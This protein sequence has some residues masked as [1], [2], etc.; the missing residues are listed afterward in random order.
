MADTFRIVRPSW[1]GRPA[2]VLDLNAAPYSLVRDSLALEAGPLNPIDAP[3]AGRWGGSVVAGTTPAN[4]TVAVELL[5]VSSTA[6][7]ALAAWETAAAL[8]V[9]TEAGLELEWRPDG[10]S[11]S[12]YL[13]LRGPASI[14]PGYRWVEFAGA[15]M[16]RLAVSWP[17]A[18]LAHGRPLDYLERFD[19]TALDADWT[20][21]AGSGTYELRGGELVPT[22]TATKRLRLA[23]PG[24]TYGDVR[25]TARL[26]VAG[27]LGG[28][29]HLARMATDGSDNGLGG[30]FANGL[31]TVRRYVAGVATSV[32]TT[33]AP[34]LTVGEWWLVVGFE[35]RL[36]YVELWSSEP[37]MIPDG[38]VS[39]VAVASYLMSDADY[40][41]YR[42]GHP[43]ARFTP[44]SVTEGY[45]PVSVEA[46]RY[47]SP[48]V[49]AVGSLRTPTVVELDGEVPGTAPALVDVRVAVNATTYPAT[50]GGDATGTGGE[51]WPVYAAIG[52]EQGAARP[53]AIDGTVETTEGTSPW[54][55]TYTGVVAAGATVATTTSWRKYGTTALLVTTVATFA[56]GVGRNVPH[57]PRKGETLVA[58]AWLQSLAGTSVAMIRCKA[59]G[60]DATDRSTPSITCP[61]AGAL[62]GLAVG[63]FTADGDDLCLALVTPSAT[64]STFR[65]DGVGIAPAI[66]AVLASSIAAATTRTL[67]VTA[68]PPDLPAGT[69]YALIV[70]AATAA[71][72][73]VRVTSASSTTWSIDR[74]VEGSTPHA[75]VAS[76]TTIYVLDMPLEA[77]RGAGGAQPFGVLNA[78]A[79]AA[80]GGT[81][82]GTLAH[83]D[84]TYVDGD[85]YWSTFAGAAASSVERWIVD[86]RWLEADP[87]R[88]TI[89]VAVYMRY[90]ID[91]DVVNPRATLQLAPFGNPS[92]VYAPPLEGASSVSLPD[93]GDTNVD[94]RFAY[95]G[96]LAIPAGGPSQI[97]LTIEGDAGSAGI[98]AFDHLWL[99]PRRS[100]LSSPEGKALG[101]SYPSFVPAA[102]AAERL[103]R[104]DGRGAW[105]S[106]VLGLKP[107][108]PYH[109]LGG[110]ALELEPGSR[111]RFAVKLSTMVP[112]DPTPALTDSE[113][114]ETPTVV[115]LSVT[116]RYRLGRGA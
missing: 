64:A 95:L 71:A 29:Y 4:G 17:I 40:A 115:G 105:R 51:T 48:A 92:G 93:P 14:A 8:S 23:G 24:Y 35:R 30:S 13:E 66:P 33:A 113:Y 22:S 100:M 69:F 76:G 90:A 12:T 18:P 41:L 2:V 75:T 84:A 15:R 49:A 52:L 112:N 70:N 83:G 56:T 32:G 94:F 106:A 88:D 98:V 59:N 72:E 26:R 7:L 28:A 37:S 25:M 53:N 62:Y 3:V 43:T 110:A 45:G 57:R 36:A 11:R 47:G 99:M 65:A 86:P 67:T 54:Q 104:A 103:V 60:G 85:L 55:T 20:A 87:F 82:A 31:L 63:P 79:A 42:R 96:T 1:P 5:V 19:G 78:N 39:P 38:T 27:A 44:G 16:L 34:A 77:F 9:S 116:P 80:F 50:R 111:A 21:D 6:D 74:G 91:G 109:G 107:Y 108:V 10:A 101:S 102:T 46:F 89:D 114:G 68:N 61:T 58:W 97:R 81:L 73:L